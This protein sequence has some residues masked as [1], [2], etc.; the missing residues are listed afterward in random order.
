MSCRACMGFSDAVGIHNETGGDVVD[1]SFEFEQ[2]ANRRQII[3]V[4]LAGIVW[5]GPGAL[6]NDSAGVRR[7]QASSSTDEELDAA[8][9]AT[10][11]RVL[12]FIGGPKDNAAAQLER[13]LMLQL[14]ARW[15]VFEEIET[16]RAKEASLTSS[17]KSDSEDITPPAWTPRLSYYDPKESATARSLLLDFKSLRNRLKQ[18]ARTTPQEGEGDSD[19]RDADSSVGEGPEEDKAEKAETAEAE[20]PQQ[21][22]DVKP[23][24]GT[25]SRSVEEDEHEDGVTEGPAPAPPPRRGR[26]AARCARSSC[27]RSSASPSAGRRPSPARAA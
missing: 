7:D 2:D 27:R 9:D 5:M 3:W 16:Q 13:D 25:E 26:A 4:R 17:I 22:T 10:Q 15:A 12:R 18:V 1:D 6:M 14:Y 24:E 23:R 8:T 20:A 21:L 11:T 19:P